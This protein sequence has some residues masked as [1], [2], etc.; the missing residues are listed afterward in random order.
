MSLLAQMRLVIHEEN[1][2][3]M[4]GSDAEAKSS[5]EDKDFVVVER[6]TA[7]VVLPSAEDHDDG[8]EYE[9]AQEDTEENEEDPFEDFPDDTDELELV[10]ARLSSLAP[11]RLQRFTGHLKRLCL[12]QN[13]VSF[14]DPE[15]FCQLQKLDELDLYDNKIKM[16]GDA[17]DQLSS[18]TILD[19]S[20]NML[21]SIPDSIAHLR[22]LRTV[23]FVQNRITKITNL[24]ASVSLTS[25]ELGGNRIRRIEGLDALVN[26]EELWIGKNKLSKLENLDNLKKLRILSLQSNRITKIENLEKLENL[27]DLYLSHNGVERIEGLE[28]NKK[29]KTLDLGTN[30]VPAIEN[31]SHLTSL[32]EL[33]LNNNKIPDLNALDRQ[34]RH[35]APLET[36]YLEGNPCQQSEGAN[37][38]RKIILSLPQVKQIDATF[39]K[40][41]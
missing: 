32:E 13:V 8:S 3:V 10:H 6:P 11:L 35:L 23:F 30:F 17:L 29:L 21:R 24:E 12:R 19:L 4:S 14:L 34:L 33:W 18:L 7:R 16:V 20:F 25:L 40:P 2:T 22:S 38:R 26:L 37:Y 28:H 15:V 27:E 41:L 36:I 1:T 5:T 31:I 39:A 9:S